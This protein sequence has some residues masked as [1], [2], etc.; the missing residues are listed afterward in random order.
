MKARRLLTAVAATAAVAAAMAP[1]AAA[2]STTGDPVGAGLWESTYSPGA[3]DDDCGAF[4]AD[5]NDFCVADDTIGVELGVRFQVTEPVMITGVRMYRADAAALTASLWAT[6]GTRL[7]EANIPAAETSFT[8]GWQ[9]VAFTR[10]V[11]VPT[12]ETFTASYYSPNATYA[13]EYGYFTDSAFQSGPLTAL[14]SV[15]G[16]GNGVFCYA[17]DCYP[18]ETFRDSNYWVSP[19]WQYPFQ[20]F[21]A[22][23]DEADWVTAK[24]G[25][26]IPVSFSL[27][28]DYGLDILADGYPKATRT[29]CPS[30]NVT[31]LEL[32]S[33][34]TATAG[35]SALS[36]DVETGDYKYVWKTSKDA[37]KKCYEFQVGLVDGSIHSLNLEFAK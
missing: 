23:V 19:L 18:D 14:Q 6:D 17:T 7:A 13:F 4:S 15:Q 12:G 33:T 10:P 36:Y 24:A 1:A 29:A 9:D 2:E 34:S 16:S 37:A 32:D 22:Q 30:S 8:P 28:G 31:M 21:S 25:R 26:A 20:G 35:N 11:S 5:V 3:Q 27:G